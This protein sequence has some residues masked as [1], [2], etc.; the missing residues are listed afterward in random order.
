MHWHPGIGIVYYMIILALILYI[1]YSHI[2]MYPTIMLGGV[3]AM[4]GETEGEKLVAYF[5][6]VNRQVS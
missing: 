4:E 6:D 2:S 5:A 1:L 3:M